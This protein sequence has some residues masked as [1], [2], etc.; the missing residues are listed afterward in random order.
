VKNTQVARVQQTRTFELRGAVACKGRQQAGVKGER[1]LIALA[2]VSA[3][4]YPTPG[5]HGSSSAAKPCRWAASWE[6]PS[7]RRQKPVAV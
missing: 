7:L 1:G 3:G 6:R 2:F 5:L 4:I